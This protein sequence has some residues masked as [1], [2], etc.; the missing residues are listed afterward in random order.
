MHQVP[1]NE[2]IRRLGSDVQRGLTAAEAAERLLRVGPNA[3][4]RRWLIRRGF[5]FARHSTCRSRLNVSRSFLSRGLTCI[6]VIGRISCQGG[7]ST[8]LIQAGA[9]A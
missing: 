8:I 3:L 4:V 9:G 5:P 2:F 7:N 1:I 6:K